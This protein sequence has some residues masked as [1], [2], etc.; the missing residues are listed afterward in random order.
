MS[1]LDFTEIKNT[2]SIEDVANRLGLKLNKTKNQLRGAC[3]S[4]E[5]D[6]RSLVITP[7]KGVFY[8]F[9]KQTGGD[10]IKLVEF[11]K[12]ITAKE[13]AAWITDSSTVP[14]V[15]AEETPEAEPRG[16]FKPLEY[17]EADHPAVQALG[18][19]PLVAETLRIGFAPRGILKGTVA[20]PVRLAD[21]T[22][23]GY[24]GITEAVLPPDWKGV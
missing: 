10:V 4:G 12:N 6:K 14:T 13:A 3:P 20:I 17:L 7:D 11:V 9:A 5:G 21:G 23:C 1:Y 18:F 2:Y 24:V 19:D 16:G 22:L 8:S 15:P